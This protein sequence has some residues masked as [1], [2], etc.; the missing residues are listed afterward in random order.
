MGWLKREDAADTLQEEQ[1]DWRQHG[2]VQAAEQ[3]D[4][5]G[6]R[7][8]M[9]QT[10]YQQHDRSDKLP[11]Q[12]QREMRQGVF[13]VDDLLGGDHEHTHQSIGEG[14]K[15]QRSVGEQ[16]VHQAHDK[17]AQEGRLARCVEGNEDGGKDDEIGRSPLQADEPLEADLEAQDEVGEDEVEDPTHGNGSGQYAAQGLVLGQHHDVVEL[18]QLRARL[19]ENLVEQGILAG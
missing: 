8:R 13:A 6:R 19:D 3:E 7:W 17:R 5:Y 16:I 4:G 12:C 15:A 11:D 1:N 2:G 18:G 10:L 9:Q 14:I